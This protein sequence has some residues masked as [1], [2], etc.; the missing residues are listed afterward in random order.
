MSDADIQPVVTRF[1]PSPSGALHVGGA[2]T[3]LFNWAF[4][5][6]H[7]GRFILRIED[8]DQARSSAQS[9]RGIIDDMIWLG[10]D[11]DEGPDPETDDPYPIESQLGDAGPYFQSQR[12]DIYRAHLQKLIDSGRAYECF[13]TKDELDADRAAAKAKK[14]DYRYDPTDM[15]NASDAQKQAWR[16][17][18]RP[19]VWR[20]RAP[21]KD[22]TV[23]DEVLGEVTV[24]AAQLDDLIIFKADGFPTY[25]F[26][27]VVDDA[28]M[29]VTHVI[30]GQEHLNNAPKHVALMEALGFDRPKFAHLPLIFNP[31]G[32]KMSKR[33][34]AKAARH[35]F[36][37]IPQS[38]RDA[39][40]EDAIWF[41]TVG[42]PDDEKDA[43]H[44]E[45]TG[46]LEMF[47]DKRSDDLFIAILL[48]QRLKA[49]LP[50]ID[51]MDFRENGYLPEVLVNYLALLGW[52]PGENHER[53]DQ[54]F[55]AHEF[56]LE[57][58]GKSNAKFDRDKLR[59]F[60]ADSIREQLSMD[61]FESKVRDL[62]KLKPQYQK[63][64][65]VLS[66]QFSNFTAQYQV[67]SVTV[68]DPYVQ[69]AFFVADDDAIVFDD[70]AVKKVLHKNDGEGLTWLAKFHDELT[71]LEP[72]TGEAAHSLI[73]TFCETNEIGMGK[74]AQPL[75]VAI[76]GGTVTPPID[77]TLEILGRNRTLQRIARCIKVCANP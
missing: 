58:V 30:R 7:R 23:H 63:Y 27:V 13:K 1:A 73:K 10:I 75:R 35:L 52:N 62:V 36:D 55:L 48:A 5:R 24:T 66:D 11:W 65:D 68:E 49:N 14:R 53:F 44:V 26:A 43:R 34:K 50:E 25:H 70:K 15:L 22:I 32:S 2:R 18:G 72:W 3:A 46:R 16:D 76:S 71:K 20:F 77:A 67:R 39:F 12:L 64:V 57:R 29:G 19:S 42:T 47:L 69:G 45:I 61:N 40:I 56:S 33:D 74:V 59:A 9:T 51:V 60:N 37:Q 54:T 21:G 17:E 31:D 41:S 6:K 38:E 8:T 4:A 28:L